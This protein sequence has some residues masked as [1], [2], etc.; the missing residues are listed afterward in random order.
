MFLYHMIHSDKS[1]YLASLFFF[2]SPNSIIDI[3]L[4]LSKEIEDPN[5]RKEAY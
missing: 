1:W 3:C 2:F 4:T 5:G